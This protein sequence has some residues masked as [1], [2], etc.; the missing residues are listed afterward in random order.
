MRRT[1]VWITICLCLFSLFLSG[2]RTRATSPPYSMAYIYFAARGQYTQAVDQAGKALNEVS[3]DFFALS[4]DGNLQM[5]DKTD[6]AFISEM[7]ARGIQVCPFLSNHWDQNLGSRALQN[8][9]NLADQVARAV[10]TY[11]LDGIHVDIEN[12]TLEDRGTYAEFVQLLRDRMPDKTIAVAVAANP[13]GT[14]AGWHGSYDYTLLSRAADY[15][16]VM[17]YDEFA[18]GEYQGPTASIGFVEASIRYAVAQAPAEKIVLGIPFYGRYWNTA[19]S[20]GGYGASLGQIEQIVSQ[21]GGNAWMNESTG[22]PVADVAIGSWQ[23]LPSI[24]GRVLQ[25]GHYRFYYENAES[26]RRK[27][28]LVGQ[29]GLKGAGVWSLGQESPGLWD[30]YREKLNP[31]AGAAGISGNWATPYIQTMLSYGWMKGTPQ[32]FEPDRAMTRAET[33]TLLVRALGLDNDTPSAPSFDDTRSHWADRYIRIARGYGIVYGRSETCFAP[34]EP[35]LRKELVVLADR[36]QGGLGKGYDIQYVFRDVDTGEEWSFYPIIRLSNYRVVQGDS[37]GYFHPLRP[38][39]R[40]ETA[41]VMA[42][43]APYL[44]KAEEIRNGMNRVTADGET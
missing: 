15:L 22:S 2:S 35:V 39:T 7:H 37:E 6:P 28:A 26:I 43:I 20:Y 42:R 40:A 23:T 30:A 24:Y 31:F 32:G 5:T 12:M 3:P 27:L 11:N 14:S 17:A 44:Y 16:L 4:T 19:L 25:P 36:C 34:D 38:I 29:Y 33:A 10:F 8:R 21:Y 41:A 1:T 13:K 18:Q 9:W